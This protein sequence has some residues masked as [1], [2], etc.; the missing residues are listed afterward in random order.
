MRIRNVLRPS[1]DCIYMVLPKIFHANKF[2]HTIF[3][4]VLPFNVWI[5]RNVFNFV[6]NC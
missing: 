2:L 4:T 3:K 6:E 5:F 1:F